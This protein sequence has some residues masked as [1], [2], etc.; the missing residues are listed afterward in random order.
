[1]SVTGGSRWARFRRYRCR[2]TNKTS[3][4]EQTCHSSCIDADLFESLV[5]SYVVN[6]LKNPMVL[7]RDLQRH[8]DS[9]EGNIG[10]EIARLDKEI[11]E[12]KRQEKNYAKMAADP[13]FD[14]DIVK[15][16]NAPVLALRQEKERE[17]EVLEAQKARHDD[18]AV[19]EEQL[20]EYCQKIGEDIDSVTDFDGKRKVLAAFD[21]MVSGTKDEVKITANINPECIDS[22]QNATTI[23][24]TWASGLNGSYKYTLVVRG[25]S[26]WSTFR[27]QP[28]R[29]RNSRGIIPLSRRIVEKRR[30]LGLTLTELADHIGVSSEYLY[31]WEHGRRL[32]TGTDMQVL[33]EWI[34]ADTED[35][36]DIGSIFG[37]SG[38]ASPKTTFGISPDHIG[39]L[40]KAKRIEL[41]MT[42]RELAK[43]IGVSQSSIS[44]WERS[45][46]TPYYYNYELLC[47]WLTGEIN[48]RSSLGKEYDKRT[49]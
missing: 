16:A 4:G 35:T 3:V 26:P 39:K 14:V 44:G 24:R 48:G 11:K 22:I 17:K 10:E 28:K 38:S 46:T 21:V 36:E 49:S 29:S 5:W 33:R 6:A 25:Q 42:G 45:G 34:I 40:V 13:D 30:K 8:L 31:D 15:T 12:L 32:P 7:V 41:A 18:A 43:Q 23:A 27:P 9:G 1:M 19:I 2:A 47:D 37:P 20:T